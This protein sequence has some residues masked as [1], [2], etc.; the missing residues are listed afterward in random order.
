M[1]DKDLNTFEGP[2]AI[3]DFLNPD[4]APYIPL[5]E[6][7]TNLNPYADNGVRIFAKLMNMLPLTNVKSLPAIQSFH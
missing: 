6:L 4:N 1:T 7:P 3:L 5:V 2:H